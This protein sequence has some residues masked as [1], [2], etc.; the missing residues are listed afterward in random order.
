MSLVPLSCLYLGRYVGFK[1]WYA[2]Y[3]LCAPK[4]TRSELVTTRKHMFQR[5]YDEETCASPFVTL[6]E[7]M[8]FPL[9]RAVNILCSVAAVLYAAIVLPYFI[10]PWV[11]MLE[12]TFNLVG[13][14][15]WFDGEHE[16]AAG[17][18]GA[19]S[20]VAGVAL[21]LGYTRFQQ[22]PEVWVTFLV[23]TWAVAAMFIGHPVFVWIHRHGWMPCSKKGS[24]MC[25]DAFLMGTEDLGAA[26]FGALGFITTV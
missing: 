7:T 18:F 5:T 20:L 11:L 19:L 16:F 21:L 4:T 13:L 15:M 12:V 24:T 14:T 9:P 22:P 3:F 26:L 1:I 8:P 6:S 10:A 2:G 17:F 25:C 23:L